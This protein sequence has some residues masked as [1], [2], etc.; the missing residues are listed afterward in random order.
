MNIEVK[1]DELYLIVHNREV[2]EVKR[3]NLFYSILELKKLNPVYRNHNQSSYQDAKGFI[4]CFIGSTVYRDLGYDVI[5]VDKIF[6]VLESQFNINEQYLLANYTYRILAN[7]DYEKESSELKKRVNCLKTAILKS[8]KYKFGKYVKLFL[9]KSTY[10]IWTILLALIIVFVF[11]IM[12]YLPAPFESW[13]L[14]EV[15]YD[16]YSNNFIANHLLN[17]LGSPLDMNTDFN[18]RPVGGIGLIILMLIKS[19]Y[20]VFIVNFLYS[21]L[22]DLINNN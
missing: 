17:V 21:K 13:K 16:G 1:L 19:F 22:N 12:L 8:E 15:T 9:H 20:I 4:T 5:N 3:S 6:K 14:F 10:S 2:N 18:I 11:S 7:N